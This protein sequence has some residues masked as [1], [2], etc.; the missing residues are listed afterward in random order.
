MDLGNTITIDL[1]NC[2]TMSKH[3]PPTYFEFYR[4]FQD[5]LQL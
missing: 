1:F 2:K 5:L 4:N 3:Q